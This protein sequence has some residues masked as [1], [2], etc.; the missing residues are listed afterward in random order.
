MESGSNK[1]LFTL[2]AVVVFGIFLSLSYYLYQDSFKGILASVMD[3]TSQRTNIM[4]NVGD[5]IFE[6]P[7]VTFAR[8]GSGTGPIISMKPLDYYLNETYILSFSLTLNS[9]EIRTIGGHLLGTST[10]CQV[11]VNDQ[12]MTANHTIAYNTWYSGVPVTMA[13]GD[14]INV[15]VVFNQKEPCWQYTDNPIKI[16]PNRDWNT[17]NC[18]Y[19]YDYNATINNIALT[20][21]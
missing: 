16:Q 9:G 15:K 1:S 21:M 3:K 20:Q 8:S 5:T 14:T 2:I 12:L 18:G 11:Y 4:L 19:S 7:T 10:D 13:V 6:Q 17:T